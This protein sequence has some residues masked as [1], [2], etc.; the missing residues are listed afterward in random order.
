MLVRLQL[1][2]LVRDSRSF[3]VLHQAVNIGQPTGRIVALHLMLRLLPYIRRLAEVAH[4]ARS[5]PLTWQRLPDLRRGVRV[6]LRLA[7]Q[8]KAACVEKRWAGLS[9]SSQRQLHDLYDKLSSSDPCQTYFQKLV[10]WR[11]QEEEVTALFSPFGLTRWSLQ[12]SWRNALQHVIE[13]VV[14]MHGAQIIHRDL[15]W[16]NVVRHPGTGRFILIDFDDAV[17]LVAG[18]APKVGVD[19]LDPN[20]HAPACFEGDHAFEVDVWSLGRMMQEA[21]SVA[22]DHRDVLRELSEDMMRN[23]KS[24]SI[25]EVST[26]FSALLQ[27][28]AG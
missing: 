11:E 22:G 6:S 10:A 20:T 12:E 23:Y 19:Q 17:H 26:R 9:R 13:A 16:P 15:R 25:N 27:S 21:A 5:M 18:T 8:D 2:A 7:V 1:G 28:C 3:E 4:E 24:I 14:V